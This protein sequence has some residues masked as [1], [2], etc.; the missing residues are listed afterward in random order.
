MLEGK[1][2]EHGEED[3]REILPDKR[4]CQ[5]RSGKIKSKRKMGECRAKWKGPRHRQARKKRENQRIQIQQGVWEVCNRGSSGVPGDRSARERKT[6]T[7]FRCENERR[8]NRYWTKGEERR[9]RMCY[10]ERERERKERWEIVN[11]D[12][13]EIGWKKEIWQRRDRMEKERGGELKQKCYY[14]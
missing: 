9:C 12:R 11:E 7:R 2:K 8:E 14:F 4:V 3:E 13:R 10:E 5:W 6:M 1:E